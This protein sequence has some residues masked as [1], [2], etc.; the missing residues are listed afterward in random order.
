MFFRRKKQKV[1][2]KV[3]R[4]LVV[5]SSVKGENNFSFYTT[6]NSS[7]VYLKGKDAKM[8]LDVDYWNINN[9]ANETTIL[10]FKV[11]K[12]AEKYEVANFIELELGFNN[13][14]YSSRKKDISP[15]FNIKL[16]KARE[17]KESK[18]NG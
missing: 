7:K 16:L 9:S 18:Y 2:P 15:V 1:E 8:E 11:K 4:S 3:H 10:E 13:D 12:E 17:K 6:E 5:D 14:Y